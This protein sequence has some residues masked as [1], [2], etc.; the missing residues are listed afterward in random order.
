MPQSS[1]FLLCP[2]AP[3]A[4]SGLLGVPQR[5]RFRVH[6]PG[7]VKAA[8]ELSAKLQTRPIT[9]EGLGWAAG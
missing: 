4:P 6:T 1:L 9:A 7:P 5:V 3:A 2:D 8:W